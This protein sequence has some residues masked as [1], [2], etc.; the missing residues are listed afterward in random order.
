MNCHHERWTAVFNN[1]FHYKRKITKK[2][3]AHHNVIFVRM[4]VFQNA[5][6]HASPVAES[7]FDD[8]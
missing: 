1:F 4:S 8:D 7:L 6:A 2:I 3:L 5:K